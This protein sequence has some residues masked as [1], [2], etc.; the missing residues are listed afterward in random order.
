LAVPVFFRTIEQT[1]LSTWLRTTDSL[2][3][4]Y[5]VL[6]FHTLGLTLLAGTNALVDLR[7]LGIAHEI[8]L[9]P[10]K[11][12]FAVMWTGLGINIVTGSLL[13]TAYPTKALTN[14]VFYLKLILITL[15]VIAMRMVYVQVFEDTSLT[16]AAMMAKGK[17][18]A[19]WSLFFWI[20]VIVAGRLLPETSRYMT[21]GHAGSG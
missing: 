4:F 9:K 6:L 12:F 18:I 10:L 3:G 19:K 20:A 2:F 1:G 16:E 11:R 14:P 15:G 13:V 7:I 17:V 5:F 21:Y 8:P